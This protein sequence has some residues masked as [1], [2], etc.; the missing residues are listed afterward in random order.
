MEI[1][2]WAKKHILYCPIHMKCPAKDL[3]GVIQQKWDMS[4]QMIN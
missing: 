3:I 2:V 4:N 1:S